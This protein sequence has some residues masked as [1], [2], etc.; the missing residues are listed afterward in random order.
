MPLFQSQNF[1]SENVQ[2]IFFADNSRQKNIKKQAE[3][4]DDIRTMIQR[5]KTICAISSNLTLNQR[6]DGNKKITPPTIT[7]WKE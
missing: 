2:C 1:N 4:H 6:T 3:G 5:S 7:E